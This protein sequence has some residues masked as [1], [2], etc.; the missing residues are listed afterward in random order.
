MIRTVKP[1]WASRPHPI[2]VATSLGALAFALMLALTPI[3]SLLGFVALPAAL[4]AV[5][6][7]LTIGYLASAEALKRCA[8][9]SPDRRLA[10]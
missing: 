1:A 10:S 8:L 2:L 6:V 9:A 3:G 4:L 7:G 5:I